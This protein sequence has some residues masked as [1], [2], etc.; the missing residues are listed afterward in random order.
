MANEPERP[1]EKLLRDAARKRREAAGTPFE[2]HPATRRLLQGEVARR[3]AKP[4][5]E[6]RPLSS[7]VAQLWPRFAWG[8]SILAVLGVAVW[9]LLPGTRGDKPQAFLAKNQPVSEAIPA[10]EPLGLAPT[11]PAVVPPPPAET[12]PMKPAAAAHADKSEAEPRGSARQ[13]QAEEK[14]L[15]KDAFREP[16]PGKGVDKL[17]P[18][19]V[20]QGAD[21]KQAAES[22]MAASGGARPQGPVGTVNGAYERRYGL[23]AKAAP[24]ASAPAAP[25]LAAPVAATAAAATAFSADESLKLA[26]DRSG[27]PTLAYKSLT[28]SASANRLKSSPAATDGLARSA[29]LALK[30]DKSFGVAQRFTQVV[31]GSKKKATPADEPAPA[32]PVLASFQV[33][34]AGSELRIVD[35]DGSVYR[36]YVQLADAARRA[37]AVRLE[38][39]AAAPTTRAPK[40]AVEERYGARLDSDQL[41]AQPYHFRVTGTNRSLNKNVVFTGNFLPATR[42]ASPPRATTNLSAGTGLGGFQTRSAQQFPLLLPNSRISGKVVVGNGKAVE[43]NAEPASP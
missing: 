1:I 29:A 16:S 37:R 27:Q 14:Q 9:V 22:H 40:D 20:S 2:L 8:L 13:L 15:A 3:F 21:R 5:R 10:E 30:E 19:S 23:A 12:S 7:V 36:G 18:A 39:P 41:A 26:D 28:E 42:V 25:A 35:G 4:Q 17:L 43:I 34:Q 6:T 31:P 33:E 11:L 38:T 32:Q 24:P